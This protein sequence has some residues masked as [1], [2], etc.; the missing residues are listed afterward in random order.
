MIY[1][2]ISCPIKQ[3]RETIMS[4]FCNQSNV[5]V[6]FYYLFVSSRL[7]KTCLISQNS[8]SLPTN[9]SRDQAYRLNPLTNDLCTSGVCANGFC[10]DGLCSITTVSNVAFLFFSQ[11]VYCARCVRCA[12]AS[13]SNKQRTHS[14]QTSSSNTKNNRTRHISCLGS[15][16]SIT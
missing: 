14:N 8:L 5:F 2:A 12:H 9:R 16:R 6:T 4:S 3:F 10:A 7:N 15:G 13:A 1:A 11:R